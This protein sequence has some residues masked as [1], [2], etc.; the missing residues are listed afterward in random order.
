MHVGNVV[1]IGNSDVM[2]RLD[3]KSAASI[4]LAIRGVR[5]GHLAPCEETEHDDIRRG[6]GAMLCMYVRR[7]LIQ[8]VSE[9]LAGQ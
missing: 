2:G 7:H 4:A 1:C 5:H 8:T 9:E 3:I 6:V